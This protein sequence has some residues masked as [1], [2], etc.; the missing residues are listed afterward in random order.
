MKNDSRKRKIYKRNCPLCDSVIEHINVTSYY[1]AIRLNR[2][3]NKCKGKVISDIIKGERQP[4][5]KKQKQGRWSDR[6]NRERSRKIK[7]SWVERR[8]SS[9]VRD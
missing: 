6:E 7:L 9:N 4:R 1:A 8:K 3:C 2:V 5:E